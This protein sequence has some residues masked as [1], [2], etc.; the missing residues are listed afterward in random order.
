MASESFIQARQADWKALTDLLDQAQRSPSRLSPQAVQTL[1]QLYR[2][3]ASDLAVAQR[4]FPEQ[5]VTQYLNQLVARAHA[6]VYRSEPLAL[7]RIWRF[8]TTGFPRVYRELLPFTLAAALF[9]LVPTAAAWTA[10]AIDPE[11]ARWLLPAEV[12]D[13]IPQIEDGQLWT[14]IPINE[15]PYASG[16]IMTNNIQVSFL[17]FGGGVTAGLLTVWALIFNGLLLG[18]LSG[19]TAHYG[20][21][22]E[23]WTFVIGHGVVEL[24][25]IVMAGG[26][27]LR[28][29]WAII[30]P[31]DYRRREALALAASRAV[32]LVIGCVPLLVFAG[33]IEGFISPAENIPWP[34]HYAV[35][36]G[37]GL[38]LYTYLLLAGRERKDVKRRVRVRAAK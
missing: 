6:S 36:L 24:S 4:D 32:R 30:H 1:G 11:S 5:R 13:L 16:A 26:A 22:G 38:L 19:L 33:I 12:Q 3:A 17:A 20:L 25:V 35:G 9:F 14:N 37:T 8:V 34:L 7:G 15:R 18:G 2:A 28:L 29:G 23:L 27:G 21:V 31:G 10:T